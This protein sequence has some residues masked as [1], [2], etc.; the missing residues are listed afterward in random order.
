MENE[1]KIKDQNL[2]KKKRKRNK[3]RKLEKQNYCNL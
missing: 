1:L 2:K 3:R